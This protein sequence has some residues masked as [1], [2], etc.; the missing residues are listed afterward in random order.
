M[1][2]ERRGA[3]AVFCSASEVAP[4]YINH[5]QQFGRLLAQNGFEMVYGGTDEGLMK[6]MADVIQ[7]EGSRVIGITIPRF[8]PRS[9]K[10]ADEIIL[11]ENLRERKVKMLDKCVAVAGL[12]GGIGT[13]DELTEVMELRRQEVH[14]KPIV[15][16][17]TD[18]FYDGLKMQLERM[19]SERFF[20]HTIDSVIHFADTPED[21][22]T[23]LLDNLPQK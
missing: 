15:L 9:R 2:A 7:S 19:H 17:N 12:P 18:G 14:G 22:M 3:V 8:H 11:A 1:T 16:L 5:A 20:A 13:L 10:N 21:A 23:Y 6:V 4:K